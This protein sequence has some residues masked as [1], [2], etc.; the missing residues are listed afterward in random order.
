[1]KRLSLIAVL[2]PLSLAAA[3]EGPSLESMFPRRADVLVDAAGIARLP[4]PAEV[5]ADV[6]PS[7]SDV[8]LLDSSGAEIPYV[9][10]SGGGSEPFDSQRVVP[11]V[12]DV[13][14]DRLY[15]DLRPIRYTERFTVVV[16]PDPVAG[17][18]VLQLTPSRREFVARVRVHDEAGALLAEAP[19]FRLA[20]LARGRDTVVLPASGAERR[21]VVSIESEHDWLSPAF[22]LRGRSA[23]IGPDEI[24]V[25]LALSGKTRERGASVYVLERPV[26]LVPGA[27][28]VTTTTPWFDRTVEVWD[29]GAGRAD[30]HLGSSRIARVDAGIVVADEREVPVRAAGGDRLL[31]RILDGDSPPLEAVEFHAVVQRPALVFHVATAGSPAA[32]LVFGGNRVRAPQYDLAALRTRPGETPE[33]VRA[34]AQPL[35]SGRAAHRARLGELRANPAWRETPSLAFAQRAGAGVDARRFSHRRSLVVRPSHEGLARLRLGAGEAAVARPD[36]ADLR[37]VDGQDRQWPY[38]LERDADREWKELPTPQ[39]FRDGHRSI[40]TLTL[41]VTPLSPDQIEIDS[42]VEFFDRAVRVRG[43]DEQGEERVLA[44]SRLHRRASDPRPVVI[45]LLTTRVTA[46]SIDVENGDDA[47]LPLEVRVRVPVHDL[48]LVAPDGEYTLLLGDPSGEAPRYELA[49]VRGVVL[50][51]P[52]AVVDGGPLEPNERFRPR[53]RFA[54][55]EGLQAG[56]WIA[57][58]A[59]IGVLLALT[60]RLVRAEPPAASSAPP[61]PGAGAPPAPSP[62]NPQ[63]SPPPPPPSPPPPAV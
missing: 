7:L 37:V 13:T 19:L 36:L 42:P 5:L 59:A 32:T 25:P 28:R 10:D 61:P 47:P 24:E 9:I 52:S 18:W 34:A 60:V 45:E 14:R 41:P 62:E 23:E 17:R 33:G 27:L 29:E 26:G 22:L 11:E 1:M 39:P 31:V 51:A 48:Y 2:V 35:L 30:A 3:P 56:V 8:R 6:Q 40:Y 54:G 63:D 16:P 12:V 46:L 58:I 50:A 38:L 53:S 49:H 21:V 57:L 43:Q 4:L 44:T 55:P 15:P 20:S